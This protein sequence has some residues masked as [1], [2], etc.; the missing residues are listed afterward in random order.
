MQPLAGDDDPIVVA[1][2]SLT[3]RSK[4]GFEM[5]NGNHQKARHKHKSRTLQRLEIWTDST[6]PQPTDE[7]YA[8]G[9]VTVDFEYCPDDCSNNAL[10]HDHVVFETPNGKNLK[11]SSDKSH[12]IGD[13]AN[14]NPVWIDHQPNQPGPPKQGT[15]KQVILSGDLDHTPTNPYVCV[16][17]RCQ[18]ELH[19]WCGNGP[20][21]CP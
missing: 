7:F 18:V 15:V 13:E 3:I 4:Y 19:Y 14:L 2:G 9:N 11:V 10:P 17:G 16:Q 21:A 5:D 6:A 8:R 12:P 20:T 1:G